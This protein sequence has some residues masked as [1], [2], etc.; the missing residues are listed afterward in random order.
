MPRLFVHWLAMILLVVASSATAQEGPKR[1]LLLA[2]GPDGHPKGT[3]EYVA[4]QN[5]VKKCL[6]GV[7]QVEATIVRC[8]GDWPEGPQLLAKA[9]GVVLFVSEGA[10]WL[11][12]DPARRAAFA[13]LAKR[14]GGLSVIHWGMGTRAAENIE[15]FVNLFGACHGGPDR[16]YKV[17]E[18][19][20]IVAAKD[21]PIMAGLADFRI[22]EE[23]YYQLKTRPE[24]L[25]VP[26]VRAEI[27]GE[28]PMVAWAWERGDG[29]RSF[30]YSG[31]H[32][33][34]QWGR[35]EYQ[36]FLAQGVLWTLKVTPPR[37]KFPA[38]VSA[39]DLRLE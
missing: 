29:G 21:H 31:C 9:D 27:D 33:H 25:L 1:L 37:E 11:N 32:F 13:D 18:T 36:R 12:A 38:L 39:G 24:T 14:S 20:F 10:K 4:G 5:V 23:F 17:L 30:G 28:Q 35:P 3:H 7:P 6:S 19:Q 16:K 8:D 26:L 34:E 15:P 22:H 2:Q